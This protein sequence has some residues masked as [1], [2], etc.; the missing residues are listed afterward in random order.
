[1]SALPAR[2]QFPRSLRYPHRSRLTD[3]QQFLVDLWGKA[4]TLA[5]LEDTSAAHASDIIDWQTRAAAGT[6][7]GIVKPAKSLRYIRLYKGGSEMIE[8]NMLAWTGKD[9]MDFW[10]ST[11]DDTEND[12][13]DDP[14]TCWFTFV[15]EPMG[16][17]ASGYTEIEYRLADGV[18]KGKVDEKE[19]DDAG[20]TFHREAQGSKERAR[21]FIEDIL[22]VYWTIRFVGVSGCIIRERETDPIDTISCAINTSTPV[23]NNSM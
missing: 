13:V 23:I 22:G 3:H 14:K 20:F 10:A 17:F 5:G 18:D 7:V 1:M 4:Q 16:R 15:R 21:C 6:E 9:D 2:I 12:F 19:L 8:A 11:P